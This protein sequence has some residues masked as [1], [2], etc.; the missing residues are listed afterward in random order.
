MVPVLL[1][2][3]WS[4]SVAG[5]TV[6][7]PL[8]CQPFPVGA[9]LCCDHSVVGTAH[10]M[11]AFHRSAAGG[12]LRRPAGVSAARAVP[13]GDREHFEAVTCQSHL[14]EASS[15]VCLHLLSLRELGNSTA[16]LLR[17]PSV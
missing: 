2:S 14:P 16:V 10:A 8:P 9:W 6:I 3:A 15:S 12:R 1:L 11:P 4:M 17:S 5:W 13:A 7:N